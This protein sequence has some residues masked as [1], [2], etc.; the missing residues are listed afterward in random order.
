MGKNQKK[1]FD[2]SLPWSRDI[3]T[4]GMSLSFYNPPMIATYSQF[5]TTIME[6]NKSTSTP[7]YDTLISFFSHTGT[8][9]DSPIHCDESAWP[10]DQIPLNRFWSKGVVVNIPK[11]ELEEIGPEDLEG[12]TPK[13]Q[14]DEI[15]IINTGW[16]ENFCGPI[17][18]WNRAVY[19]AS[20]NPGLTEE[21]ARWL[22]KKGIKL[23]GV[24]YLGVDHPK[25]W[26]TGDGS[27]AVHKSLLSNNIPMIQGLAGQID[28]VSG[29]KCTIVCPP[30]NLVNGD[31]FPVRVLAMPE[32]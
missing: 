19:Y 13:I 21:G 24:D 7:F 32:E 29:K 25:Y 17:T 31:S 9:I 15:V 5:G 26:H 4:V 16:H 10:L 20:K 8:H 30:V 22:I 3:P 23:V 1:I 2:L 6:K 12:A 27:W 18:D 28:E 14:A 11:G